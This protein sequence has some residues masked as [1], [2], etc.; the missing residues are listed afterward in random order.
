M[1][2]IRNVDCETAQALAACAASHRGG[3]SARFYR[4][5]CRKPSLAPSFLKMWELGVWGTL[6]DPLSIRG[7]LFGRYFFLKTRAA[8]A[9]KKRRSGWRIE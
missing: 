6:S 4:Q 8:S 5:C 2:L 1:R 9:E 3:P 7:A